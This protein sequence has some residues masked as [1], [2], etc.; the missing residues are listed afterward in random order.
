MVFITC[1]IPIQTSLRQGSQI[2]FSK[3]LPITN[4]PDYFFKHFEL[5][6]GTPNFNCPIQL[7]CVSQSLQFFVWRRVNKTLHKTSHNDFVK[8][9]PLPENLKKMFWSTTTVTR[10]LPNATV[11]VTNRRWSMFKTNMKM[12]QSANIANMLTGNMETI[13]TPKNDL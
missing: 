2:I 8:K 4:M 10:K 5:Q 11:S 13:L 3:M 6:R 9:F 1:D 7:H 12:K